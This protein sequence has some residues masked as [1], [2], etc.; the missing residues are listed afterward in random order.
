M[1]SPS[2]PFIVVANPMES[3]LLADFVRAAVAK[4]PDAVFLCAGDLLNVF[5]EPGEDH[6]GSMFFEIYGELLPRELGRLQARGFARPEDSPLIGPLHAFFD[7]AG[8]HQQ[9]AL[10][11]AEARYRRL[12]AALVPALGGRPFLFIPGN[13]DYPAEAARAAIG[14]PSLRQLDVTTATEGGLT[15]AG[16][17]GIPRSAQPLHK[18]AAISPYELADAEWEA[19]VLSMWGAEVLVTHLSPHESPALLDFAHR[20][21]VRLV[22]SRAPFDLYKTGC[23]RGDSRCLALPDG[24][25]LL[26]ARPFEPERNT[27]FVVRLP[28]DRKLAPSVDTYVWSPH[29]PAPR[30]AA[31]AP[32]GLRSAPA[33][34]AS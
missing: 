9:R 24:T 27:A 19:R 22:L 28:A 30:R 8:E 1:I 32:V 5:P 11:M 13:M 7:P 33:T 6:L 15:V 10:A 3:A 4:Y 2:S 12:F 23:C 16:V 25:L 21:P 14:H 31:A 29:A 17:G 26:T 18:V 20:S 34:A